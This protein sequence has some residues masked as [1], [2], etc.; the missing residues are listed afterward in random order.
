MKL[1]YVGLVFSLAPSLAA[2]L[3]ATL[4]EQCGRLDNTDV[5]GFF[6]E[7]GPGSSVAYDA[8]L[9]RSDFREWGFALANPNLHR[10]D[11]VRAVI[12]DLDASTVEN[13][14][15]WVYP[16]DLVNPGNPDFQNPSAGI[17]FPLFGTAAPGVA[18]AFVFD[19]V[20]PSPVTVSNAGDVY[21]EAVFDGARAPEAAMGLLFGDSI[22]GATTF[23]IGN[24]R[25]DQTGH[26]I[27][28]G[29]YTLAFDLA[30]NATFALESQTLM[31]P[32]VGES[33]GLALAVQT[34]Q[35]S[36]PGSTA[37]MLSA[38]WFSALQPSAVTDRLDNSRADNFGLLWSDGRFPGQPVQ[39]LLA[40]NGFNPLPIQLDALVPGSTGRLC[41]DPGVAFVTLGSP[42]ANF[43]GEAMVTFPVVAAAR[44]SLMGLEFAYQ[45]FF[46]DIFNSAVHGSNCVLQQW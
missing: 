40:A 11:G 33:A 7:G 8:I 17:T 38:S 2:Q 32:L 13:V 42:I 20:F 3:P 9:S 12:G 31:T 14:D 10:V 1:L 44:G 28:A 29:G 36:L 22:S 15:I 24:Q 21:L 25:T 26:G 45:A 35:A 5:T 34:N 6:R 4:N 43:D 30:A 46:L 18:Q 27:G 37:P 39:F 19:L 16:E 41:V 23:D